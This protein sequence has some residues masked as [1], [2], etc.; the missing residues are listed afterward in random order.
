MAYQRAMIKM[1]M[2]PNTPALEERFTQPDGFEW[3]SFT[4][5]SAHGARDIRVGLFAANKAVAT[6]VILPGLSEFG[7]KYFE[8]CRNLNAQRI[9]VFVIDWFGQ[10]KSGR[11]LEIPHKRHSYSFDE[12]LRDLD[13]MMNTFITPDNNTPLVMLGHSMGGNI[14]LRYLDQHPDIFKA[15]AFSAPFL[16]LRTA[17]MLPR[18][19]TKAILATMNKIAPRQYGPGQSRWRLELRENYGSNIF[20][21]DPIRDRL[22]N[23]W[24]ETEPKLQQGGVTW[25]WIYAAMQS[26]FAIERAAPS[27]KTPTLMGKAEK[28]EVVDNHAIDN[29]AQMMGAQVMELNGA[30]HEIF[31]EQDTIRQPFLDAVLDHIKTHIR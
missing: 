23:H 5:Q 26:C 18:F 16:G 22:H 21:S 6:V 11:Y 19:I 10:G 15:A 30:R 9:N 13:M 28:D 1:V 3:R 17:H 24:C 31:M 7:E 8:I 25:G 20:S 29:V 12:D 2:T 14:G 4:R 27:I